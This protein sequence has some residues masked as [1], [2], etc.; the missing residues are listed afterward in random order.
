[1]PGQLPDKSYGQIA[2]EAHPASQAVDAPWETL[3]L[4][5]RSAWE[6]AAQTA[7][8]AAASRDTA[9]PYEDGD[10]MVLGP[11]VFAAADRSVLNWDGANYAPQAG[12]AS[13][14]RVTIHE[15]RWNASVDVDR[16]FAAGFIAADGGIVV[17]HDEDEF[18]RRCDGDGF[19]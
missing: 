10:V 15:R 6:G 5:D 19:A 3:D 17:C 18:T 2:Y 9:Y 14:P 11:G 12:P 4:E 8:A 7:I 16:S 1:M 13:E